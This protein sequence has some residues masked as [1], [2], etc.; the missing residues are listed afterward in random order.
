MSQYLKFLR[1]YMMSESNT[2]E[3]SI[4][5]LRPSWALAAYLMEVANFCPKHILNISHNEIT[6]CNSKSSL[7]E[8][9]SL[10]VVC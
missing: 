6:F 5:N 1:Y 2:E 3:A 8:L 4:R 10:L 7:S 9:D